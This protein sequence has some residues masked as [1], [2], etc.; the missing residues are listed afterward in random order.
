MYKDLNSVASIL[1]ECCVLFTGLTPV[2]SQS[3]TLCLL[4]MKKTCQFVS[5]GCETLQDVSAT[6]PS[7]TVLKKTKITGFYHLQQPICT[8]KSFSSRFIK[9]VPLLPK[10]ADMF[11][12]GEC[13]IYKL[14]NCFVC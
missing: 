14:F 10:V 12:H 9:M 6:M 5:V 1:G 11:S 7:P 4:C 13:F 2:K 3:S 8:T